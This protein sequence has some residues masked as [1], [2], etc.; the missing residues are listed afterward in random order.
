MEPSSKFILDGLER[1]EYTELIAL[2]SNANRK[3]V[4]VNPRRQEMPLLWI[5][6]W[7]S[8]QRDCHLLN[9]MLRK[10][11]EKEV[12]VLMD[13][14]GS[15]RQTQCSF[16][17]DKVRL[18][19]RSIVEGRHYESSGKADLGHIAD[20]VGTPGGPTLHAPL[21]VREKVIHTI[22]EDIA[23]MPMSYNQSIDVAFFWNKGEYS[24]YGFLRRDVAK[25]ID[26]IHQSKYDEKNK[27]E[28]FVKVVA[29]DEEGMEAGNLQYDYLEALVSS[30]IVVV[31]QRDEWEDAYSLME[32]L[33]SG[34]L[35]AVDRMLAPPEGMIN[36]TNCIFYDGMS[37]LRRLIRYY[38]N[39]DTERKAIAQKGWELVMGRHRSWHRIETILFGKPLTLVDQPYESA[40]PR[41]S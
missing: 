35:V 32:S 2:T 11:D 30:K 1:S 41:E 26:S 15:Q 16:W 25:N 28:T 39:H 9:K 3:T 40:P 29:N 38:L 7:G 10:R 5:A 31:S 18:I 19:K 21:V 27:I 20:N 24:H 23:A 6:D 33:A 12:V 17:N 8:M 37:S 22:K 13:F 34:A 36:N 4:Q 14:S